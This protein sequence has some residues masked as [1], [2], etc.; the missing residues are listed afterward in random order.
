MSDAEVEK[1]AEAEGIMDEALVSERGDVPVEKV[2]FPQVPVW[3]WG[4]DN[5]KVIEG[6]KV[7]TGHRVDA[8]EAT[9]CECLEHMDRAVS[10]LSP[11]FRKYGGTLGKI[12]TQFL[13]SREVIREEMTRLAYRNLL[14]VVTDNPG[15]R[16][17]LN[18]HLATAEKEAR[19]KPR[20]APDTILEAPMDG[21]EDVDPVD[22]PPTPDPPK[23]D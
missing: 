18:A 21:A 20:G 8:F 5:F 12:A 3:P 15:A 10:E 11:G 4:L 6:I 22:N 13:E 19:D 1:A 17:V 14:A 7:T 16:R 9:R 2:E 23:T